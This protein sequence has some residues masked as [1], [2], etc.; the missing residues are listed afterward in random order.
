MSDL[1]NIPPEIEIL[2]ERAKEL[3]QDLI[4]EFEKCIKVGEEVSLRA[5][6]LTHEVLERIR[7]ALDHSMRKYWNKKILCN[8]S[9]KERK[10]KINLYFPIRSNLNSFKKYLKKVKMED[11]EITD[12]PMYD[13]LLENQPFMKEFNNWLYSL[14]E[15]TGTGKHEKFVNQKQKKIC[16]FKAE[17]ETG[18]VSWMP[19]YLKFDPNDPEIDIKM[20]GA[21]IDPYHQFL[22]SNP[23]TTIKI[24]TSIDFH[25]EKESIL[26]EGRISAPFFCLV[27]IEQAHRL[28]KKMMRLI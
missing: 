10:G 20:I 25:L 24:E 14:T 2:F 17:S 4:V 19:Q 26:W 23:Y 11:L 8:L 13:F 9:E 22:V 21:P 1:H 27:A 6:C 18:S 15:L 5:K 12:K 28:V 3:R 7:I 16:I